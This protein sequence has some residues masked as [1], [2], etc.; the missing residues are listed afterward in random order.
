MSISRGKSF[1]W[2]I[3]FLKAYLVKR[4]YY[5]ATDCDHLTYVPLANPLAVYLTWCSFS[6]SHYANIQICEERCWV[7]FEFLFTKKKTKSLISRAKRKWIRSIFMARTI[8]NVDL[9]MAKKFRDCEDTSV[10]VKNKRNAKRQRS[11]EMRINCLEWGLLS[12]REI[13]LAFTEK[14]Y[15]SFAIVRRIRRHPHRELTFAFLPA[16]SSKQ[17]PGAWRDFA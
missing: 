6:R 1:S 12:H 5:K 8:T 4:I 17:S 2:I 13:P 10:K 3:K 9:I 16:I 15:F 14:R 7:G 11:L